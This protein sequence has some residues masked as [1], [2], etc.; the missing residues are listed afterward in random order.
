MPRR[1]RRTY[2]I[3]SAQHYDGGQWVRTPRLVQRLERRSDPYAAR[4]GREYGASIA[5]V[6]PTA[7]GHE[8]IEQREHALGAVD[9]G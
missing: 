4:L 3:L 8:A 2:L 6:E 9:K 5:V 1:I 7:F